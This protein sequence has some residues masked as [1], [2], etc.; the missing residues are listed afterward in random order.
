MGQLEKILLVDDDA[1]FRFTMCEYFR[2]RNYEIEAFSSTAEAWAQLKEKRSTPDVVIS[3][4]QIP[5][6]MDGIEFTQKVKSILPSLPVIL[7]TGFGSLDTAIEAMRAGAYN[8]ILK[9]FKMEDVELFVRLAVQH[10]K[11]Q[12]DNTALRQTVQNSWKLNDQSIIGKSAAMQ[13]IFDLI[14]RVSQ[15]NANVLLNGASGTGKE[16]IARSIHANGAR[17]DKPFVAINC[18]AVPEA[19]LESELFGHEKGSFTGA[20]QAKRGLF[21]V[22]EG[23]TLFLD[24]IGD[25]DVSIQSKLLRVLQ[26]KKIRPVGSNEDKEI[27]VRIIAATHVDLKKAISE[28]K[29]REDLFYRLAVIP[30]EVPLLQDRLEDIPLLANH[31]LRKHSALNRSPV[32][33]ISHLAMKKLMS[34]QWLGNVRELE[35]VI[36]RA[37]VLASGREIAEADIMEPSIMRREGSSSESNMLFSD[38]PTL[39]ELE[40]RYMKIVLEKTK[41]R[42]E[43]A[44]KILGIN[45]R[46]L[47]RKERE[48][49]WVAADENEES[50]E[51]LA[52]DESSY[53]PH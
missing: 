1:T 2:T 37:V 32:R 33:T 35:N 38:F 43:R 40:K 25:M 22:A 12:D 6:Q 20:F 14:K 5:G 18:S 19:L 26:D 41:G 47:Y 10:S 51:G 16:A 27:D 50:D 45:R 21:E 36:E 9:P 28:S 3:D 52:A 46:T 30:I 39:D 44:S 49:G 8:Y 42:K 34:R 4:I 7:I 24:E 13:K 15:T 48:F 11:L 31:F 53:S 23:G 29:F 17:G